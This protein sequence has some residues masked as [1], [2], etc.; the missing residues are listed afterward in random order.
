MSKQQE[1]YASLGISVAGIA[2]WALLV[3]YLT[4]RFSFPGVI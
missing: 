4:T 3:A 1:M 2:G